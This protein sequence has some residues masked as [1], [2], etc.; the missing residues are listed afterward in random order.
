[1]SVF[2]IW[3]QCYHQR[4]KHFKT[5]HLA[6]YVFCYYVTS[7]INVTLCET[8]GCNFLPYRG[9]LRQ[10]LIKVKKTIYTVDERKLSLKILLVTEQQST[11]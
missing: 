4:A 10:Q 8:G 11:G 1:M 5:S 3:Y 7:I 9:R 6:F 2:N